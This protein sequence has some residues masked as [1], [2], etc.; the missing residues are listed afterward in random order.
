M[1]NTRL[2]CAA[3]LNLF[4]KTFDSF[5]SNP[6]ANVAQ[7]NEKNEQPYEIKKKSI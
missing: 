1:F 3:R 6:R 7:K 4:L 2:A 5:N